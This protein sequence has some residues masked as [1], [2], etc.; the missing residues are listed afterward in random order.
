MTFF[1][2][3]MTLSKF[4]TVFVSTNISKQIQT[5][6]MSPTTLQLKIALT[7]FY[8]FKVPA[9]PND[10]W[11]DIIKLTTRA[12]NATAARERLVRDRDCRPHICR[13]CGHNRCSWTGV[14]PRADDN[15]CRWCRATDGIA[16]R[17][18]YHFDRLYRFRHK[19]EEDARQYWID[20]SQPIPT[21]NCDCGCNGSLKKCFTTAEWRFTTGSLSDLFHKP[22][23]MEQ[24][25]QF[26]PSK[27]NLSQLVVRSQTWRHN[28]LPTKK[29][30]AL[31]DAIRMD[32]RRAWVT[33]RDGRRTSSLMEPDT[34]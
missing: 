29:H 14:D 27:V 24:M 6:L 28:A 1:Y 33:R 34:D 18:T 16:R 25:D 31:L 2:R 8:G 22:L 23:A 19:D 9:L 32:R 5:D 17:R 11:M 30:I 21:A 12:R 13:Y 20:R 10:I 15:L 7:R 3:G 26:G 4:E